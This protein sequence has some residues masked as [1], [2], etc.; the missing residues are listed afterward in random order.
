MF[1]GIPDV[2]CWSH[3]GS[4]LGEIAI[5]QRVGDHVNQLLLVA[6]PAGKGFLSVS[7]N[8]QVM[9]INESFVDTDLFSV[10]YVTSHKITCSTE[11]FDFTFDNSDLFINQAV[12]VRKSMDQLTAHGLFGQTHKKVVYHT[13]IKYIEGSVDD[14]LVND[15]NIWSNDFFYNQFKN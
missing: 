6:G 10:T 5:Q 2:N 15:Q 3:P 4:Y 11:E 14:Y 8:G 9:K 13:A 7:L 12:G 1:N